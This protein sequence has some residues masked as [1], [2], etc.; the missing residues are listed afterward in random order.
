M[1]IE[2]AIHYELTNTDAIS[3]L[4]GT[5]LYPIAEV[6]QGTQ[7][8]Y[9]TYQRISGPRERHQVGAGV[10]AARYQFN[11]Y[12][13]TQKE[14]SEL[15]AALR[16]KLDRYRDDMGEAGSTI[17]VRGAFVQNDSDHSTPPTGGTQVGPIWQVV[18]VIFWYVE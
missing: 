7:T 2:E 11:C 18:D 15:G 6:P 4:I 8:E 13:V 3:A 5:R 14:A 12:G 10:C 17:S 16:T 1:S 9:M